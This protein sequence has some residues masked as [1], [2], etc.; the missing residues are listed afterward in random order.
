MLCVHCFSTVCCEWCFTLVNVIVVIKITIV[1][2][3]EIVSSR[4]IFRKCVL[5][6]DRKKLGKNKF[7][8]IHVKHFILYYKIMLTFCFLFFCHRLPLYCSKIDMFIVQ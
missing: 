7:Y 5:W 1:G 2:L 4:Q 3:L 8:I 6:C